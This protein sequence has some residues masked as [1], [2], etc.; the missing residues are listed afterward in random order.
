MLTVTQTIV[1]SSLLFALSFIITGAILIA[2]GRVPKIISIVCINEEFYQSSQHRGHRVR[3][4]SFNSSKE[5]HFGG[6]C[7]LRCIILV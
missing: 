1:R 2:S 5:T 4:V 7:F 6:R 3:F